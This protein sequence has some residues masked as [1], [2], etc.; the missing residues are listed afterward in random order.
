M[1]SSASRKIATATARRVAQ[2]R[3]FSSAALSDNDVV[4]VSAART[5][6]GAF[7]G[8]FASLPAPKLGSIVIEEVIERAGIAKSDVQEVYMG[9]VCS[10]GIGQAPTKQAVLGAG[11]PDTVPCTT[12]NKVC[13][14]GMKTIMMAAQSIQ[15][16]HNDVM[17]AGGME[18]M[19]KIP[20]YLDARNGFKY[21][22]GALVDGLA[23]DGLTDPYDNQPMGMCAEKCADDFSFTRE[24]QDAY[25]KQ[26]YER[27]VEA[28]SSGKFEKE[29]VS[30]AVPQ[31]RGDPKMISQ[32]EEPFKLDVAKLPA[33]R[34]AFKKDGSVTAANASSINDGACAL[35]L[36]SAKAAK[37]RGC[38][39][40]ARIR[41]YGDAA[42]TPIDFTTAP[43]DAV[44]IALKRAGMSLG[45]VEYHEINEAFAVVAMANARIMDLDLDRVNVNGGAVA[46]GHP[47]GC[48]G[49]RIVTTLVNVLEQNDATVGAASICNGGGGA[50]ALVVERL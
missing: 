49:A 15:L 8:D 4:I 16:G 35:V 23:F 10:A 40:L 41:G 47:I 38:V 3:A 50:S 6:L 25:A 28:S 42:K 48:S 2:P 24:E 14:S 37:E 18:N 31:R 44:P 9:N 19:T 30:V 5:P 36:M 7:M 45:D 13:A 43:A 33:L 27:A 32:D 22:N 26:S 20:H 29:I 46:L 39:P 21:G 12:V 17:I 1:L 11:L 34:P